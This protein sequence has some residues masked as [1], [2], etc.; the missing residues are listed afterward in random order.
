MSWSSSQ[1]VSKHDAPLLITGVAVTVAV[2]WL[3][4]VRLLAAP[5]QSP[6]PVVDQPDLV[7]QVEQV[8]QKTEQRTEQE[9]ENERRETTAHT[10]ARS[11]PEERVLSSASPTPSLALSQ[12]GDGDPDMRLKMNRALKAASLLYQEQLITL[13][14]RRQLKGLI[15]DQNTEILR[16]VELYKAGSMDVVKLLEGMRSFVCDE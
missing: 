6:L 8:E 1:Q 9:E 13:E 12:A 2:A 15:L 10:S 11:L 16:L 14:Q 3:V 5:C 7:E 4:R